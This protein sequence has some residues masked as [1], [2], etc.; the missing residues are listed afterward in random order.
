MLKCP[1][2]RHA[3]RN[4]RCDDS[5]QSNKCSASSLSMLQFKIC[6][7]TVAISCEQL[8]IGY[9]E[10]EWKAVDRWRQVTC[11]C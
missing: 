11:A 5:S 9:F 2:S 1:I 3:N 10:S 4:A 8:T 6:S 7:G